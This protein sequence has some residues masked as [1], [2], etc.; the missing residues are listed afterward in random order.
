MADYLTEE[1][2]EDIHSNSIAFPM[3]LAENGEPD[4]LL[5]AL[6]ISDIGELNVIGV[7]ASIELETHTNAGNITTA[8][9]I[10]VESYKAHHSKFQIENDPGDN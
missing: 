4:K 8:T 9:Y 5:K 10:L 7:P 6:I 1:Q 2:L 3:F